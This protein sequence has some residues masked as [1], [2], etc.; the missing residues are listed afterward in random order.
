MNNDMVKIP[1]CPQVLFLER[2]VLTA[3]RAVSGFCFGRVWARS[4]KELNS[5][6]TRL[7]CTFAH[8]DERR[9][10]SVTNP[11]LNY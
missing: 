10:Q 11:I 7:F 5:E 4:V 1:G 9:A 2:T 8:S 6:R 3:L